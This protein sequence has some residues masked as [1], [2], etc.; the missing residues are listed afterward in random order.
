MSPPM[1]P[2]G[3]AGDISLSSDRT[4]GPGSYHD[5]AVRNHHLTLDP[6][7]YVIT[8]QLTLDNGSGSITGTGVTL[9]FA[10]GGS[11]PTPCSM[12]QPAGS[13]IVTSGDVTLSAPASGPTQNLL[14]MYDRNN[15][16]DLSLRPET[17]TT[18]GTIYA[19]GAAMH[20]GGSGTATL[21]S[22]VVADALTG[23]SGAAVNLTYDPAENV[24]V[25]HVPT[26]IQ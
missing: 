21:R 12:G 26:L 1:I 6:G 25:Q 4:I 20:V 11:S 24:T 16:A 17:V 23:D 15:R 13:L 2:P 10:C 19:L 9:Y 14:V 7:L 18:T 22:M 3:P 5:I 8:G